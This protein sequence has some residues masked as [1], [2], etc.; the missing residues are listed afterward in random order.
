MNNG[1]CWLKRSHLSPTSNAAKLKEFNDF[2]SYILKE[3]PI[4]RLFVESRINPTTLISFCNNTKHL[5]NRYGTWT[6]EDKNCDGVF[7]QHYKLLEAIKFPFKD[8]K[9]N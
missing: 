4:T 7:L 1:D 8:D 6:V 3:Y 5:W 9:E 2:V